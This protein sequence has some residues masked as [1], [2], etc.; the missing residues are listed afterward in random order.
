LAFIIRIYHDARSSECQ[1]S[2]I[3]TPYS[4]LKHK[5]NKHEQHHRLPANSNPAPVT[6][7]SSP[8]FHIKP[9]D[10]ARYRYLLVDISQLFS[11]DML[12][13]LGF[14]RGRVWQ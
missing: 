7:K 8:H 11:N 9:S 1:K 4:T 10:S 14:S 12:F 3:K 13:G 6:L 5:Y 2:H